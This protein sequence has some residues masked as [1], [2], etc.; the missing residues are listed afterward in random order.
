MILLGALGK[1]LHCDLVFFIISVFN[2]VYVPDS[3]EMLVKTINLGYSPLH[4]EGLVSV[5]FTPTSAVFDC[6]VT[7]L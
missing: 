7:S 1:L 5:S 2:E 3:V 6:Y 4:H